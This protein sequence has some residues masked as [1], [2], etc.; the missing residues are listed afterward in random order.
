[1]ECKQY[2][3]GTSVFQLKYPKELQLPETLELFSC[4]NLPPDAVFTLSGSGRMQEYG[5]RLMGEMGLRAYLLERGA[6][7]LHASY[8]VHRGK[9][10]LFTAPSQTGKSTQAEL[11]RRCRGAEIVNGDRALVQKTENGFTANGIFYC[12]SSE[13]C[14]NIT[15][16][17]SAIVV[18]GQGNNRLTR[19]SGVQALKALMPQ[20]AYDITAPAEIL[21]I[22]SLLAELA[23]SVPL[24]YLEAAPEESSVKALEEGLKG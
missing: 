5:T 9:A 20:C 2:R 24:L 10:I 16:P 18:L 15:A 8:I 12:G 3:L 1:M 7:V 23:D 11:W 13:I 17:L 19:L 4:D 14:R 6:F 21:Q 22:T